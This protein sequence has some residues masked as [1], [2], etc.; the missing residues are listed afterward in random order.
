MN[1]KG[2]TLVELLVV[3]AIIGILSAIAVANLNTLKEKAQTV[4]V[5]HDI[6]VILRAIKNARFEKDSVLRDITGEWYTAKFCM[7]IDVRNIDIQNTHP[8]TTCMNDWDDAMNEIAIYSGMTIS[9]SLRDPW[10]SPYF[11]DENQGDPAWSCSAKDTLRSAGP[12]GIITENPGD[13]E[14]TDNINFF[15]PLFDKCP[16]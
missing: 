1:K 13:S 12:D 14:N 4:K 3:I 5:E 16:Y 7:N 10:G 9:D 15:I 6:N 8:Y 11:L 2:F